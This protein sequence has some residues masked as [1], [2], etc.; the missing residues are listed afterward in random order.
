MSREEVS[1]Y[2]RE[3]N[4]ILDTV[5]DVH[6]LGG[7]PV[8]PGTLVELPSSFDFRTAMGNCNIAPQNTTSCYASFAVSVAESFS[9]R[10]CSGNYSKNENYEMVLFSSQAI[11]SCDGANNGCGGGDADKAMRYIVTNGLPTEKCFKNYFNEGSTESGSIFCPLACEDKSSLEDST[12]FPNY[13]YRLSGSNVLNQMYEEIMYNGPVVARM[14]HSPDMDAYRSGVFSHF[15]SEFDY[16]F[17]VRIKG[18]GEIN[19]TP[20]WIVQTTFGPSFGQGGYMLVM[21]GTNE[22]GIEEAVY[23]IMPDLQEVLERTA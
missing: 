3:F 19:Q 5:D 13:Y 1:H 21:R 11:L 17:W 2:L 10:L 15:S 6:Q 22:S 18:W 9:E 7:A 8:A 14:H 4:R 16:Y 23:A 20:Y 12:Y